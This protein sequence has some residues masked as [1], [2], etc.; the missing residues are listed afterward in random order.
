MQINLMLVVFPIYGHDQRTQGT[1]NI[2]RKRNTR[3]CTSII[4][5][6]FKWIWTLNLMHNHYSK[7]IDAV[8]GVYYI[9]VPDKN[10]GQNIF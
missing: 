5:V 9:E 8:S 7:E 6:Q 2:C 10:M 1:T 4:M 3:V